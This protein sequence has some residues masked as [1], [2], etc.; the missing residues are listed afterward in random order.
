M[1]NIEMVRAARE[2][3]PN[4]P[5]VLIAKELGVSREFVRQCLIKLNL[6]T[7]VDIRKN[8][9]G[10]VR[11][12]FRYSVRLSPN[13]VGAVCEL[14]VCADL[15]Q[16]GFHVFRSVSPHAP[17][18][19]VVLIGCDLLRVE[20]RAAKK[21]VCSTLGDHD[22]LAAVNPDGEIIYSPS[23]DGLTKNT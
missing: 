7:R 4:L 20:V 10:V 19:L 3:N 17:C 5:A 11:N 13:N 14:Q 2:R 12:P 16:R 15:L 9:N 22:I 8:R 6:P 23:L 21:G 1:K 18:D